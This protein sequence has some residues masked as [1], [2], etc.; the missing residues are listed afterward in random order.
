VKVGGFLVHA[1]PGNFVQREPA[2]R[3]GRGGY[4]EVVAMAQPSK[5]QLRT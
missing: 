5:W 3:A 4:V 2:G 1:E